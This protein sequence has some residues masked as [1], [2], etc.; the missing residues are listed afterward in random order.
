MGHKARLA[1]GPRKFFLF[2]LFAITPEKSLRPFLASLTLYE[3]V[4]PEFL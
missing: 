4:S 3:V 1:L 2:R